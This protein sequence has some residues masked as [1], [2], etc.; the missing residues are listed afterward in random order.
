M[1]ARMILSSMTSRFILK[2]FEKENAKDIRM[3]D[4]QK[5]II[6][7]QTPFRFRMYKE[8]QLFCGKV[9]WTKKIAMERGDELILTTYRNGNEKEICVR[10]ERTGGL[11]I[12]EV[13]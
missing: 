7:V 13:K 1:G 9:N 12:Y 4:V 3:N 5:F 11:H 2:H 6:T 10:I 8:A